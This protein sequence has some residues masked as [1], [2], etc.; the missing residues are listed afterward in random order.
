MIPEHVGTVYSERSLGVATLALN[1]GLATAL[2]HA[3]HPAFAG[4]RVATLALGT[5]VGAGFVADG[6]LVRGPRGEYPRLND[7]PLPGGGTIE[8]ALGGAALTPDPSAEAKARAIEAFRLASTVLRETLYPNVIVVG[9][10]VGLSPWLR[11]HFQSDEVPSPFGLDAG[12]EGA[13]SLAQW[14]L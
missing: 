8:E 4:R 7:L 3:R 12:L 1:D 11:Q 6:E 9:G 13:M 2:A 5:G 14:G 10:A